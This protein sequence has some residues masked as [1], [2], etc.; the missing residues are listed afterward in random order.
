MTKLFIVER[1]EEGLLVL[2]DGSAVET[3]D[4]PIG[5]MWAMEEMGEKGWMI[6]LPGGTT[7]PD[8]RFWPFMWHTTM[9]KSQGKGWEVTGEAPN[10]TVTPSIFCDPPNGWHG[11]ITNGEIVG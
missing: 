4:A 3:L 7:W 2:P 1:N 6:R 11:Y 9:G 8:G 10:L 5:A